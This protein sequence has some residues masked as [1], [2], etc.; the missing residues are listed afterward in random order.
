MRPVTGFFTDAYNTVKYQLSETAFMAANSKT[1]LDVAS[2]EDVLRNFVK[3]KFS[4]SQNLLDEIEICLP[5]LID[6]EEKQYTR[7]E[8]EERSQAALREVYQPLRD[9]GSTLRGELAVF[10]VRNVCAVDIKSEELLWEEDES[11]RLG[12]GVFGAVYRGQMRRNE[13]LKNVALKVYKEELAASNAS[14]VVEEVEFLR[15]V[16]SR[17]NV[18]YFLCL[19]VCIFVFLSLLTIVCN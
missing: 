2:K 1:Y 4:G 8:N 13:E 12:S 17:D 11:S 3:D 7:L 5:K 16:I 10:G 19:F 14:A 15:W 6:A 18:F 9:E